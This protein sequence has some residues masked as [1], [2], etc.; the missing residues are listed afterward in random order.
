[1]SEVDDLTIGTD[2]LRHRQVLFGKGV[3]RLADDLKIAFDSLAKESIAKISCFISP[4]GNGE[5]ESAGI[6]NIP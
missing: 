5:N 4:L 1:M 6:D 2:L 3:Q